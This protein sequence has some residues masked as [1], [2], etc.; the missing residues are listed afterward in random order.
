MHCNPRHRRMLRIDQKVLR[1]DYIQPQWARAWSANEADHP[2]S[3][4]Q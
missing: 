4:P 3:L 2:D 1:S